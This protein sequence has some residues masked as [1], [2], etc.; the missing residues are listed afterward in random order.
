MDFE[1]IFKNK[2]NTR[3]SK[4]GNKGVVS[5]F[6]M[7]AIGLAALWYNEGRFNYY[8]ASKKT[9]PV[10]YL[11]EADPNS[12]NGHSFSGNLGKIKALNGTYIQSFENYMY[13][14]RSTQIYSWVKS[15]DSKDRVTW[16]KKWTKDVQ[17]NSRNNGIT[18]TLDGPHR[19]IQPK[20]NI[21]ELNISNDVYFVDETVNIDPSQIQLSDLGKEHHLIPIG[22]YFYKLKRGNNQNELGNE[23]AYYSG[24]PYFPTASYF[25]SI[26][27][28]NAIMIKSKEKKNHIQLLINDH[29]NLHYLVKGNRAEALKTL[30]SSFAKLMWLVRFIMTVK[31]IF[32][33]YLIMNRIISLFEIPFLSSMMRTGAWI[34][35]TILGGTLSAIVMLAGM[36]AN[37][38]LLF[39]VP[40]SLTGLLFLF[41]KKKESNKSGI[42]KERLKQNTFT[43]TFDQE[44]LDI[45]PDIEKTFLNLARIALADDKL[46]KREKSFLV[47]WGKVNGLET[48]KIK[49]L[50]KKAKNNKDKDFDPMTNEEFNFLIQIAYVDGFMSI[51]ERHQ[52]NSAGKSMGKSKREI[53]AQIKENLRP[54]ENLKKSDLLLK[55]G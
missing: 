4:S 13:V 49:T 37:N 18:K 51:Q 52:I 15:R 53:S 9:T 30:K 42:I 46:D 24:L 23:R 20:F 7:V 5:G 45:K 28:K 22:N 26:K 35:S 12:K 19:F 34:F 16:S 36:I 1:S 54:I 39:F 8:Q 55:T 32:G 31:V 10:Q 29:G 33:L 44:T 41:M 40:A 48:E 47:H 2:E 43:R 17:R 14:N 3:T 11:S 6:M 21:D 25:G 50:F 38:P 27:D